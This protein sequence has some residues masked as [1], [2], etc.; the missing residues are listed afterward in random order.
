ML[1]SAEVERHMD[2]TPSNYP[3][4]AI[5]IV[6]MG[7]RF[8]GAK[9]LAEFWKNLRNGVE[10][11]RALTDQELLDA[12]ADPSALRD[13][14]YVKS[15]SV[16]DGI[17]LF[18]APF[19]GFSPKDAAIMDPQHRVFLECAWEALERAGWSADAFPGSIGVFA[20]SGMNSYLMFH[21]VPNQQLMASAGLFL[22]K[23]TG[24]DKD[25]LAT[26]VS[27]QLNLTG[28]S[29]TI[30]TACSTS[31]VAVHVACQS[32]LNRE[33]D[34][35]LAGGVTIEIPHKQGYLYREGEILSRDGHC[36]AFDAASTGTVF[37]SGAGVVVLRRLADALADGDHIHAVIRGSAINN[38]GARKVG[39]LAPSVTG[40][41]EV[42]AEALAVAEVEAES[43]SYV[44]THGTGTP[45]GDPIEIAALTQAFRRSTQA[46]GFC[47]IG[48]LKTNI[49]H[50][51]AAAG[52]AGLIKTVLAIEHKQ[53]PPSLHFVKPNPQI[54]FTSS[55]FYVNHQAA[56]WPS[57]PTPR[58]AGV[59]ALGIGGTNAHVVLEEAPAVA[60][61]DKSRPWQVLTLSAKTATALETASRDLAEHLEQHPEL[62]LADAAFTGHL[63]RKAFAH[64]RAV[65][66]G[67]GAEAIAAL[68]GANAKQDFRGQPP[69]RTGV[70][71]L[72]PGQ[73]AQYIHMARGIYQSEEIF[74]AELDRSAELLRQHLGLDLRTLLFPPEGADLAQAS[75]QLTETRIAQPALFTIEYAL[76][77]LWMSWGVQPAAMI[78]HSLGE[79]VAACVSG[80]LSLEDSLVAVAARGRLMQSVP[81]GAMLAV[82]MAETEA[83]SL[84]AGA[85][86]LAAVNGSR[87]CVLSGPS[88]AIDALAKELTAG[89]VVWQRLE[90]SHAFHS[91]SMDAILGAFAEVIRACKLHPPRIPYVSNVTGAWITPEEATDPAYWVRH[92]RQ[93]VRFADGLATLFQQAPAVMI[94]AG[95]GRV[96][97]GL[98]AR[99]PAKTEGV[100]IISSVRGPQEP[101][102]DLRFLLSALAQVW[103]AGAKIDWT[104]FHAGE[105]RQR[106]ELPT[107]P[108]ERQRYWIDAPKPQSAAPV[109]DPA[110][111]S[112]YRPAWKRAELPATNA[113][114]ATWLIF[115]DTLGL[116]A[117]IAK[118]LDRAGHTVVTVS[119]GERFAKTGKHSYVLAPANR[120]DHDR[121]L[122]G[123]VGSGLL[124]QRII[125]LWSLAAPDALRGTETLAST[126]AF[127]FYSLLYLAQAIGTQDLSEPMTLA[128]VSNELQSVDGEPAYH[129][130]RAVLLGPCKV[131]P[132]EFANIRCRSI[133]VA[134]SNADEQARAVRQILAEAGQAFSAPS[135]LVAYRGDDRWIETIE[136]AHADPTA[137]RLRQQGVYLITG[138]TGGIGL[139]IAE[140]LA[141]TVRAKLVLVSRTGQPQ[142]PDAI[143][144]LEKLGA[145]VEIA[146]ADVTDL[147]AMQRVISET[148]QKFGAINGVIHAAGVLDDGL[149][150]FKQKEAADRVLAPKVAGTLVLE[151]AL[152]GV[153]LDFF[154]LFSSVSCFTAPVGQVDYVAANSFLD[155]FAASRHAQ[156]KPWTVAI[157]WGRWGETGM[158]AEMPARRSA[159]NG[160]HPLL[161]VASASASGAVVHQTELSFNDHWVLSE[162]CLRGGDA[163]FPGT[164][165]IELARAAM[166]ERLGA[167]PLHFE[168]LSFSAPLRVARG[169]TRAIEFRASREGDAY[170]FAVA[171]APSPELPFATGSVRSL[172]AAAPKFIDP[173][174]LIQK[175]NL[176]EITYGPETQNA[177]QARHIEFGPRWRSLKR[178]HFGA[179]EAVSYLELAEEYAAD[180]EAF[181]LHPALLDAATG[182]AMLTI[183][184]YDRTEDL[185]V[186]VSYQS[187]T[188]FGRLPRRCYCHIRWPQGASVE[189][190]VAAFDLKIADEQGL[191]IA[192]IEKF[193]LRR[194][195]S[196]ALLSGDAAARAVP[197]P[198]N[199]IASA[200]G[201]RAFAAIV[202]S[203]P[204]AQ[205]LAVPATLRLDQPP[206]VQRVTRAPSYAAPSNG[207][208]RDPVEQTLAQWWQELLGLD[209]VS[210]H[211]DFF[212]IGGHSLVAV[213]LFAKIKSH[214]SLNLGLATL[215]EARTIEA[216]ASVIRK[217]EDQ[218]HQS[219]IVPIQASGS[220][221]ALFLI[222]GVGGNV[223]G[224]EDL[225]RHF[226]PDQPIYGIQ[227]QALDQTGPAL[228][229]V[230]DIAAY[231]I[232]EMRSYQPT[233]PYS[234]LGYSFGGIVAFEIA[235]QLH[236]MGEQ[237]GLVGLLDTW[238][239][240][241]FL[242]RERS[243]PLRMRLLRRAKRWREYLTQTFTGPKKFRYLKELVR[244]RLMQTIYGA[245]DAR[246]KHVPRSLS[247]VVD[248]NWFAAKNYTTHV[249]PSR[250]D[251]FRARDDKGDKELDYEMGWTGLAA[252]GLE[253]HEIPGTHAQLFSPGGAAALAEEIER[254]LERL[255]DLRSQPVPAALRLGQPAR[256][257]PSNG[258]PR[259]PVEQ[260]L[261]H[262]WQE[263]L[264]IGHVSIH[265]DFFELG[266]HSL[267]AVR[268]LTRIEKEF[269]QAV[270]LHVFFEDRTIEALADHLRSRKPAQAATI[271]PLYD[272][273]TG[274]AIY[275]VHSMGGGLATFRH[276][277]Q[278]LGPD[279]NFYGIQAH[280]D[281]VVPE[282]ASSLERMAAHYVSE[283]IAFQ[284]EGP[285]ILGGASLG[286]T[287]ALEMARQLD[288]AGRKVA[289]LISIDGAPQNTGCETSR[290]NPL[291]YW[292]LLRNVP[293][294]I[295]D[296][297]LDNFSLEVFVP[298]VRR[299]AV[300]TVKRAASPFLG[301]QKGPVYE[302]EGFMNLT[303]YSDKQAQFMRTLYTT[304]K[305]YVAK[306]YHGRVLLYQSRTE[307]LT[308][309][310]ELDQVWRGVATDL[311]VVRVPGT[312]VSLI[313]PPNVQ[314]IAAHLKQRLAALPKSNKS[315]QLS[316]QSV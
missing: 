119:A 212:E 282:F 244:D 20:G 233:G 308:H 205:V 273:G 40:Q 191:V 195:A 110:E 240:A 37:G 92:V 209:H 229:R 190:E 129:P 3:P 290:W 103:V 311:E 71:F 70:A 210:I 246:G 219:P 178:M 185:Y 75:A 95:P 266:G 160:R 79:F 93:P 55:P 260:T 201:A 207:A 17:E 59:T 187:I 67:T 182:S 43:I 184:D 197:S 81:P 170:Q 267:I 27:Y 148:R 97:S 253:V 268:L 192:E 307:P 295:I 232:R 140:H 252:E 275:C 242:N 48:S 109:A 250:L 83:R 1:P 21:L 7:A 227:S 200:A 204:L 247:N 137:S 315:E 162:H 114:R 82:Q 158:A 166:S 6:G 28:P 265:D 100:K 53:L 52:V 196:A 306:P 203:Q 261:A 174:A 206:P 35:A 58:R 99:H 231:Y 193:T 87:Q 135:D 4:A 108:F 112:Y 63:G 220:R 2:P 305:N 274:P 157:N 165:Y 262:W 142:N 124:P 94:E 288:A 54:D 155:A 86:S 263:L 183:P 16:L 301:R 280:P 57:R 293:F 215:F 279:V 105:H 62:P 101:A 249:Y 313:Q 238:H 84:A 144:S 14:N 138:G 163:L 237:V 271:I 136:P 30:Q 224:F 269:R 241:Y 69:A 285:Y 5:A 38:D 133:D 145:Q 10:S 189:K 173:A 175:C 169:K 143:Q 264:G 202:N 31:L 188:V 8:P 255:T 180:L 130:E 76:A 121:L 73:G 68:R 25:V 284:P 41:A 90:T 134:V 51:D 45:V 34:M 123:L 277:V 300:A 116:G 216:L 154:A 235:Q 270:P 32:L 80:V 228:M 117:A 23:Q 88:Q 278:A 111:I 176:R 294:W 272:K 78:G 39:Y 310:F 217:P 9:N 107:Y 239:P 106:V 276:L 222:H 89:G 243:Q 113:E 46:R 147:A 291:Y 298:R 302:L 33:C 18:D 127:S 60:P 50:L 26:R 286:A 254:C 299:R 172:A 153:A 309:L 164:G 230:E 289:L 77:K 131:I 236:A 152:E 168:R 159:S 66:C 281:L 44:E 115:A 296:D 96:L 72:F 36:R 11:I 47:G 199:T 314:R 234:F 19:F 287:V 13:P 171:A 65:V 312:H 91:A 128:I 122:E 211:D 132:R 257:V 61:S 223:V 151:A 120:A 258:A 181:H 98:A 198:A 218:K 304:F 213:R 194:L 167:G 179:N 125:H 42:V 256:P 12:G 104:R 150:Q 208:P 259:D 186:P 141:R 226:S 303:A 149:I 251:L 245:Y 22:L 297:L 74:R 15:A 85:L 221:P 214:F 102:D 24:N 49:G 292:K 316:R 126:E 29:M 118:D 139:V 283:L 64:R 156:G 161:G 56:E 248:V 146:R 225:A 177:K